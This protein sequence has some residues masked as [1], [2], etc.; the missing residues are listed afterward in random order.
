MKKLL[1][2]FISS[3]TLFM[4]VFAFEGVIKQQSIDVNSGKS[5]TITWH[6]KGDKIKMVL[7]SDGKKVELIPNYTTNSLIMF[8][9]DVQDEEGNLMYMQLNATDIQSSS[10]SV[11]AG[12]IVASKYQNKEAKTM[13]VMNN[14]NRFKVQFLPS[15]AFD[16]SK[17]SSLL[18]ESLEV[19]AIAVKGLRGF[20]VQTTLIQNDGKEKIVLRTL[21]INETSVGEREFIVPT[22][23]KKFE[24]PNQN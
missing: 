6:I 22:G 20:P 18:K 23:Y 14:G 8:S 21:S 3:I 15:I 11:A 2:V 19:Q 10:G 17:Y 4:S 13:D 1:S 16:F 7:E 24:L 9:D 5:S 12:D